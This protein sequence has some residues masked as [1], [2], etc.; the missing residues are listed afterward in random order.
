MTSSF[1]SMLLTALLVFDPTR[2][3]R[4]GKTGKKS[5]FHLY[6]QILEKDREVKEVVDL[7]LSA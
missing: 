1:T 7:E 2:K 5:L 6:R 4:S 3:E